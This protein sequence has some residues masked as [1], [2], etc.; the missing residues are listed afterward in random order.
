MPKPVQ[1]TG[2]KGY[3][4]WLAQNQPALYAR[5]REKLLANMPQDFGA[6]M[7]APRFGD[8]VL[9]DIGVDQSLVKDP[10]IQAAPTTASSSW[11]DTLSNVLSA[12]G[13]GYA[14]KKK[15][16][17]QSQL[18]QIQL[19]RIRQGLPPYPV[20]PTSLGLSTATVGL[21]LTSNTQ[22]LLIYGGGAILAVWVVTSLMGRRRA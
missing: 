2:A 12:V 10:V 5:V 19:D 11:A 16:D 21:G 22:K 18:N 14:T 8:V 20:D 9:Q 13:I 4:I 3:L 6:Y 17:A 7:P 15:I 1:V